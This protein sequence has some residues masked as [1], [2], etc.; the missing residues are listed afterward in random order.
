MTRTEIPTA[1]GRKAIERRFLS[2]FFPLSLSLSLSAVFFFSLFLSL[3]LSFSLSFS[4]SVAFF[5]YLFLSFLANV[6]DKDGKRRSENDL[7][8]FFVR[9]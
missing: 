6:T 3:P 4:L 7:S 5:L 8:L 1:S 2:S 9:C